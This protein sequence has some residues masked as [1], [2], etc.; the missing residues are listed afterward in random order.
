MDWKLLLSLNDAFRMYCLYFGFECINSP[1]NKQVSFLL[2]YYYLIFYFL[3]RIYFFVSLPLF[4]DLLE[5]LF[6]LFK[7][8]NSII[9]IGDYTDFQSY[10]EPLYCD[11]MLEQYCY[12]LEKSQVSI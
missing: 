1:I 4:L 2:L 6:F 5:Y 8:E 11:G 10:F 9:F 12:K 7:N 3:H